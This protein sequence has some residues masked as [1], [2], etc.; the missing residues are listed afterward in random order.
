[1]R[2]K[3]NMG[4]QEPP[5]IVADLNGNVIYLNNRAKTDLYPIKIGNSISKYVDLNYIRKLS[6]FDN[7]IDEI[8]RA[9]V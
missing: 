8:G 1:M 5:T 4:R 3:G 6:V 2:R 9:H 7:R